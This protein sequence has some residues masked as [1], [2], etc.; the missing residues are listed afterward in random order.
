LNHKVIGQVQ[1][2]TLK[3]QIAKSGLSNSELVRTAWAAAASFRG[4]DR[5][6]WCERRVVFV[7]APQKD[8]A[9]NNPSEIA[10]VLAKLEEIQKGSTKAEAKFRWQI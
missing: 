6:R 8:W 2:A 7:L 3:S 10:K 9:V 5:S 1:I 4:T